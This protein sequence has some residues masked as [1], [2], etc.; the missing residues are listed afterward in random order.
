M[1]IGEGQGRGQREQE[2]GGGG[3]VGGG[4]ATYQIMISTTMETRMTI[5]RTTQMDS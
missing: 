3:A 2:E 1:E 4:E 5:K